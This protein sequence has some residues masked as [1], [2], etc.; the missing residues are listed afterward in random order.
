VLLTG[1][2]GDPHARMFASL[3]DL[4]SRREVIHALRATATYG[5]GAFDLNVTGDEQH[6]GTLG[7]TA[8]A[9]LAH[10]DQAS[11]TLHAHEFDLAP[12][13]YLA[14]P[15]IG[16]GGVLDADVDLT[17][18]GPSGKVGGTL[19]LAQAELPIYPLVGTLRQGDVDVKIDGTAFSIGVNGEVGRGRLEL[20]GKG[21]LNGLLPTQGTA[22]ATIRKVTLINESQPTLDGRA[23]LELAQDGDVLRVKIGLERV[24][25]TLPDEKGSA[26]HPVSSPADIVIVHPRGK[27]APTQTTVVLGRRP[28][29]PYLIATVDLGT[30]RVESSQFRGTLTGQ[31]TATVGKEAVAIDG[32]LQTG[33]AD[34]TISD[35]RYRVDHANVRFDGSSDPLLD[36]LLTYDFSSMTLYA[37]LHGRLSAPKL[38]LRS[39]PATYSQAELLGF[40]VGGA[41]G[42][43]PA[44][45]VADVASGVASGF[46][47]GKVKA[48]VKRYTGVGFDVLKLEGATSTSTAA[49][50]LGKWVSRKLFVSY[51]QRVDGRYDENS[52][53]VE[54][55]YWIWPRVV[56]DGSA[57]DRGVDELV[58]VW[59][60][61]W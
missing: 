20:A 36:V 8:K 18:Y 56:V 42:Q 28:A 5:G 61:R 27:K 46:L 23:H 15:S 33:T 35:R 24:F 39:D 13:A 11:A 9:E 29:K 41:P 38:V 21:Q 52:S 59:T 47:A 60:K 55:E 48:G 50:T 19:H 32:A 1:T 12:L 53:E 6:G 37:A 43:A 3:A 54:G 58:V 30:V 40:L 26:L 4:S 51:R 16:V 34:V 2:I 25:A 10:L 14:P 7:L 44:Q 45:G 49:L 31:L 17:G 22:D 57:G